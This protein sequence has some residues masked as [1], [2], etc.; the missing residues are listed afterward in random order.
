[1]TNLDRFKMI[2]ESS[3]KSLEHQTALLMQISDISKAW[4]EHRVSSDTAMRLIQVRFGEFVTV[5]RDILEA[6]IPISVDYI[7]ALPADMPKE[8]RDAAIRHVD[9]IITTVDWLK[10]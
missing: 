4:S 1:M 7:Q 2:L 9:E 8:K 5:Q 3:N 10:R 6:V